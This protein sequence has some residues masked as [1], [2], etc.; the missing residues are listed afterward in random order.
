MLIR[1]EKKSE[2]VEK[3]QDFYQLNFM[4][5]V[6]QICKNILGVDIIFFNWIAFNIVL[7]FKLIKSTPFCCLI[8]EDLRCFQVL[9][10]VF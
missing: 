3:L 2:S 6:G 5:N 1:L 8:F 7:F 9:S 4:R 10:E